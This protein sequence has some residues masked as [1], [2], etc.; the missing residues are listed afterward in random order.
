MNCH[1]LGFRKTWTSS[2]EFLIVSPFK[3]HKAVQFWQLDISYDK[4]MRYPC[5]DIP[6]LLAKLVF[7]SGSKDSPYGLFCLS[8]SGDL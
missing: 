4:I 5:S 6:F 8:S 1:F 7:P 3:L 2:H